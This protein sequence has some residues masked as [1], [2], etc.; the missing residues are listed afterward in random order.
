MDLK[1]LLLQIVGWLMLPALL[2]ILFGPL[3]LAIRS[4]NRNS[5]YV[6]V[7]NI[8]TS[9]IFGLFLVNSWAEKSKAKPNKTEEPPKQ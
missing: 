3:I 6:E 1:E 9:W 2:A 4:K 8:F 5:I 7:A